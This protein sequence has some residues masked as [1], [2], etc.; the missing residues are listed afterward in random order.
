[1][2]FV[3]EGDFLF[4]IITGFLDVVLFHN[5]FGFALLTVIMLAL[6]GIYLNAVVNKHKLFAKP[7]YV[8]AF[9][10][11]S[12]TSIYTPF[13]QFSQALLIN[14]ILIM[15]IDAMLQFAQSQKPRK[16]IY[17]TG[18]ALGLAALLSFPAVVYILLLLVALSLLRNINPGEWMVGILGFLTPVY[19]AA[20]MLF[21]FDVLHWLPGWVNVGVN[22]PNAINNPLNTVGMVAGVIILFAA[23]TFILQ[24]QMGRVS[25]FVRRG[26]TAIAMSMFFSILVALITDFSIKMAW[27]VII[28]SITLITANAY[29]AEKNKAFSNFAFYFMLLLVVFCKMT[30]G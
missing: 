18:F 16:L 17:N 13:G 28:P 7:S 15:T 21:L 3:A 25:I 30:G 29:Y 20:G 5:A 1:M 27:L 4:H 12:L 26:W 8:T 19:F 6:Q 10:Y 2:P 9:V 11:I 23:G 24:S 14:W 22:L